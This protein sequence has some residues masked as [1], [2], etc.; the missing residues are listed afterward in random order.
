MESEHLDAGL[1]SGSVEHLTPLSSPARPG[2]LRLARAEFRLMHRGAPAAWKLVALGLIVGGLFAPLSHVRHAWLPIAWI[3]PVL[4]W[5][6]LGNRENRHGTG[7]MVFSTP[8][9]VW[10]PIA[11]QW[12]AGFAFAALATG[13]AGAHFA[14]AHETASFA[15]W[16]AGAAFVPAL[17]VALGASSGSGKS[18]E[19]LY[20]MLWYAGPMSGASALDYTGGSAR[21]AAL[22]WLAY[23]ALLLALALGARARRL[24]S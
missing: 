16:L 7:A 18:F 12:L 5:S 22:P 15:A 11:A 24:A 4:A 3:W 19:V 9:P 21:P 13:G 10:R 23:A 2:I 8:Q 6:P 1:A 17:A 20:V 14:L